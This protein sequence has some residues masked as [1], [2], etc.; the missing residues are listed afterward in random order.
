MGTVIG[1]TRVLLVDD[2]PVVREGLA[3]FLAQQGFDVV[4]KASTRAE[5]L[6]LVRQ[7]RPHIALVDIS[8]GKENGL[9]LLPELREASPDTKLLVVTMHDELVFAER[10][11]RSG[12]GGYVMKSEP[13]DTLLGAI[14]R[15]CEGKIA[16]SEAVSDGVLRRVSGQP[17]TAAETSIADLTDRELEVLQLVGKGMT[18]A[19]IAQALHLSP[20]TVEA[21]RARIKQKVGVDSA[22]RLTVIAANWER[23]GVLQR[24]PK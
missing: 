9:S 23:D 6:T 18:A 2:H 24:K 12:A 5:A 21:H 15:V 22:A 20:K 3:Y 4:G 13:T 8:L 7:H 14:R 17:Q 11:I 19:Q 16:V 10:A 1:G